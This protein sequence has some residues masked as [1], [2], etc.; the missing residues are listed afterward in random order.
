VPGNA[1]AEPE[2]SLQQQREVNYSYCA[3]VSREGKKKD[4]T[5]GT[6]A[7]TLQLTPATEGR[8]Q[9]GRGPTRQ[10]PSFEGGAKA[11]TFAV[12]AFALTAQSVTE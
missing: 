4:V 8:N 2:D 7:A 3:A 1:D 10:T 9:R 11:L 5:R 12:I 6:H